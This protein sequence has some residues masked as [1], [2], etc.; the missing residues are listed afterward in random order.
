MKKR[1]QAFGLVFLTAT[2]I[3]FAFQN[4]DTVP[5]AFLVWEFNASV[6]LLVLIPLLFGLAV[7]VGNAL[8]QEVRWRSSQ[9]KKVSGAP[10]GPATLPAESTAERAGSS[11]KDEEEIGA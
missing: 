2:M 4:L 11:I 1:L 5:V 3:F 10:T 8:V 9:R 7:G 6:S